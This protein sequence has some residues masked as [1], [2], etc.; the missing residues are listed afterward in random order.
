LGK[1]AAIRYGPAQGQGAGKSA[2]IEAEL[3]SDLPHP[4][5]RGSHREW[6]F[7]VVLQQVSPYI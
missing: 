2:F 3:P 5:R 6:V 4:R 7:P 1:R